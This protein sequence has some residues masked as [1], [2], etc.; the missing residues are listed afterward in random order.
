MR[1]M[2]SSGVCQLTWTLQTLPSD[3]FIQVYRGA[4]AEGREDQAELRHIADKQ[5]LRAG[6]LWTEGRQQTGASG[7]RNAGVALML[8]YL[9]AGGELRVHVSNFWDTHG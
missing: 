2:R 3:A 9:S 1:D 8:K 4:F 7:G 6:E 5:L